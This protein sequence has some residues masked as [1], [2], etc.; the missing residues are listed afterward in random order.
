M[1]PFLVVT[2]LT[3]CAPPDD[4]PVERDPCAAP[5]DDLG[6]DVVGVDDLANPIVPQVPLFPWPSDQYLVA[7]PA[8]ASGRRVSLPTDLLPE[9]ITPAMFAADDGFSRVVPMLTYLPGGVDP[10]TLPDPHDE[11]ATLA[12][13][14]PVIVVRSG[15]C[16]RVPLLAEVDANAPNAD[17]QA[18]ILRAHRALA[19]ATRYVV[20]LRDTLRSAAG[21]PIEPSAAFLSLRDAESGGG[22]AVEAWRPAFRAVHATIEDLELDPGE[23]VQAWTFTTRSEDDVVAP[24]LALQDQA[25][26]APLDRYA[27]DDVQY[28]EDG[29]KA[30]VYGTVGVPWFLDSDNRLVQDADGTPVVQETRDVPFLVTIP[31]TVT[32]P[33]EGVLVGHGFFSSIEE[34][35]WANL[36]DSL[37]LWQRPAFS[38]KFYGF[39]EEDLLATAGILGGGLEDADTI[40]H[41]QLQSHVDFTVLHRLATQVL[42]GVVKVDWG[43]GEI[44]PLAEGDLP[45]IGASNGGT[46]G[47]VI[48]ATSPVLSRSVLVVPG[49]G[50][51]H[52]LTRAVQW[53]QFGPLF[54]GRYPDPRELQLVMSL[55]QNVLDPAD[56][57][58]YAEHLLTER[59]PGRAPEVEA[60]FIEAKEDSQVANMVT[61]WVARTAGFPLITPSPV[62]VWGLDTIEEPD[63]GVPHGY[64][65][66]DLGKPPNPEGNVPPE[67]NGAHGQVREL[68]SYKL[69]VGTFLDT[70]K[71]IHPCEGPC[72]PL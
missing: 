4:A 11:G 2:L 7:D 59:Y 56:S 67:E 24:A 23:I 21:D 45:W 8:T 40:V 18:L 39:A 42:P 68:E 43:E 20:L 35:T 50:W 5:N 61:R 55:L 66:Y 47:L 15:T 71:V 3:A 70:G 17:T 51:S 33:R 72:D 29:D 36:F 25:A 34:P 38:T 52:M 63:P 14:S 65:I 48:L 26:V 27:L 58:N 13:D 53:K 46:Q 44:S 60:L 69:Q 62:D 64:T 19:P 30:L 37:T 6:G 12:D 22:E 49:G 16:E 32:G 41:Q 9:G 1:R 57:L 54:E 28:A 10:S 31:R